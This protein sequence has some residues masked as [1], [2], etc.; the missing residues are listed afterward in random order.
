MKRLPFLFVILMVVS[1]ATPMSS[2]TVRAQ[3]KTSA[4]TIALLEGEPK[5]LDPQAVS[6]ID[7]F[8]VLNNIYEGLVSYDPKTLA[9]VPGLAESWDVSKDGL[10]YT[11]HLRKGVKFQ[12]GRAMTA[13]DV[14]YTFNRLANPD[15]GISYTGLLLN[16]VKGIDAMRDK[17]AT[18]RAK[19]LEG[20]KVVDPQTV[21]ITLKSAV[22][23]F[24]N[25]LTLPGGF[26]V[27]K[28]AAEAKDFNQMP[29]GTGPYKLQEW[30]HQ[31]HLTLEANPDYWAGAPAIKTV[32]LRNIP[33]AS[34]QVIEYEGGNIDLA[35]APE[36]D[37]PR[38]RADA[39]LSKEL[40]NIPLLSIV[41]L[42]FNLKDPALS[43]PEV[44]LAL[45]MAIDRDQIVKTVLGGTGTP[46]HGLIPPGLS[47]YDKDYNPFPHDI[48]KAKD[49]LA[50]AGYKDGI[51]L[52]VRTGQVETEKRVL[53][54]IQQQVADAGIR[55][56]INS[57]EKSVWDADRAACK[58]QMGT[59]SWGMDYPDP[60]N[61]VM[62]VTG[63]TSQSRINCGYNSYPQAAEFDKMLADASSIPV[64]P[65]RDAAYR[66]IE[67]AAMDIA[68]LVPLYHGA[69]NILVNPRL[70]GTVM[71]ASSIIHFATIT[72]AQ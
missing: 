51:D 5:T 46:A 71:D 67:R 59:V 57:T 35:I 50:Q 70:Q 47:A 45:G 60:D 52:E 13:D 65:G 49:L 33:E 29:V 58:M 16:S 6:T 42:R 44:R 30:V 14:K 20:V 54:A 26:I 7:E 68:V 21:E 12:N 40:Q 1:L 22:A 41:H 72:L 48:A 8:L 31:D 39:K 34:Q 53:E 56:K 66:K 28:E 38:I 23:S 37:L 17:D 62:L 32:T 15:T 2:M 27:P 19:D 36:P 55:L 4:V 61:V 10:V 64:G 3:D 24:L 69:R 9:P 11:F 18:K 43:K 63:G 25:Q